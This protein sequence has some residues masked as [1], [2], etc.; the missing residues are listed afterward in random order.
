MDARADV[1]AQSINGGT[2]LMRAAETGHVDMV[3]LLLSRAADPN[4]RNKNNKLA[5]ELA[6]D[7][8][9]HA[10]VKELA[11]VTTVP[12]TFFQKDEKEKGKGKKGKDKK[13]KK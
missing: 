6:W 5:V 3:H 11:V 12:L 1:N 2:P 8:G 4:I 13:K 7:W 9:Q 10:I